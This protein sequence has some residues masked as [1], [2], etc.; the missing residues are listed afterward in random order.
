MAR[1]T[2]ATPEEYAEWIGQAPAPAGAARALAEATIAVDEL[3][4]TAV[5]P[6]DAEGMPTDPGHRDAVRDATCAQA[7]YARQTGDPYGQ[8]GAQYSDVTAGSVRLVRSTQPPEGMPDRHAPTAVA[9]LR[10]AGLL[11][12][13]PYV[14]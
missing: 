3:L 5:Y 11:G 14:R 8:G 9:I 7:S 6:V 10:Q 13:G 1:R 4:E 2:Y 12:H